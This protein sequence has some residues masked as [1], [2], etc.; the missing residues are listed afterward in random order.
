MRVRDFAPADYARLGEIVAA[1]EPERGRSP[2]WYRERDERWNPSLL[3]RRLVAEMNDGQVV[4][5]GEVGHQ[6]WSFHP[7]KFGMRLNVDPPFQRQGVGSALYAQ[8]MQQAEDEW[9]A[10]VLRCETREN[11]RHGVSFLE[12]RGFW[13]KNRR[14]EARLVLDRAH[15]QRFDEAQSRI[16]AQGIQ[17][18]SM[19][20][21]QQR[22]GELQMVRGLFEMEQR[23]AVDEPGYD[24]EGAMQ[25]D[26]FVANELDEASR[27]DEG[28]FLA[29][30]GQR[31]VGVSRLQRDLT[32]PL[33]LDV[34]FTGTDPQY[35][36]RG[37]ALAL[38]L[39]T[40]AYARAHGFEQIQTQNDAVNVGMLHINDELGFEREP[41]WLVYERT[42]AGVV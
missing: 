20:Q 37:I 12:H 28:S 32:Q 23:A 10:Q 9:H 1:I 19:A 31:L 3:R 15:M 27:V 39:R 4:G 13:Q 5:W 21:A 29:Y 40:L 14:W 42:V 30:L 6:W 36:G 34:G 41:A 33:H 26:Q 2:E 25:F 8:L 18:V 35:R 16:A 22:Q 38:K 17:V 11:R 24:P 7:S